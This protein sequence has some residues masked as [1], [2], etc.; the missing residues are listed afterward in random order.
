[1]AGLGVCSAVVNF[2]FPPSLPLSSFVPLRSAY[3]VEHALGETF[4][5]VVVHVQ[6]LQ[7]IK[8]VKCTWMHGHY[9]LMYK[10]EGFHR[11]LDIARISPDIG[12]VITRTVR[13]D[14]GAARCDKEVLALERLQLIVARIRANGHK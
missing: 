4:Y 9:V 1:M 10:V 11:T 5:F 3:V 13:H 2:F 14:L 6:K 7:V 8:A 12:T